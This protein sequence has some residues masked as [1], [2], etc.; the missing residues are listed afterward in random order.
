MPGITMSQPH[1]CSE[2]ETAGDTSERAIRTYLAHFLEENLRP[3]WRERM[4][5]RLQD[6]FT[7]S[8]NGGFRLNPL[9]VGLSILAA[10]ALSI[11]LYFNF[12]RL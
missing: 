6:P 5:L 8:E 9:Y 2:P 1:S 4:R 7:K 11:F 3:G 10:L 12:V